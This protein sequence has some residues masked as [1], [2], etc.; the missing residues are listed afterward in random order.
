YVRLPG[1]EVRGNA[2][3]ARD[4]DPVITVERK[5]EGPDAACTLLPGDFG[6]WDERSIDAE[7]DPL[8]FQR[9][10]EVAERVRDAVHERQQTL[11]EE[12]DSHPAVPGKAYGSGPDRCRGSKLSPHRI[13]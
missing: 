6:R 7:I 5:C 8:R 12:H 3:P 4:A 10:E 9:G 11:G 13:L 2:S 1:I